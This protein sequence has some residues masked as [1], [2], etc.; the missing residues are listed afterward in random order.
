M[1]AASSGGRGTEQAAPA[2]SIFV[3]RNAVA[4]TK[5][6]HRAALP[7]GAAGGSLRKVSVE[8]S[9]PSWADSGQGIECPHDAGYPIEAVCQSSPAP[10][11]VQ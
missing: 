2:A 9:P 4:T 5:R 10:A 7:A 6:N 8:R 3:P 11:S 1:H